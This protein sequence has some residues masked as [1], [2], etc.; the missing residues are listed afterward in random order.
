MTILMK[1]AFW[2]GPGRGQKRVQNGAKTLFFLGNSM[3][4]KLGK[5]ENVIVRNFAVIS[6]APKITL[7]LQCFLTSEHL[8]EGECP[9]PR[10]LAPFFK[11]EKSTKKHKETH[12][13]S[14][15]S[16][17]T[18]KFFMWGPLLLEN[19]GQGATHLK[20]LGVHWG[21]LHSLCGYFFVCVF[22]FSVAVFGS[23]Q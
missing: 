9:D 1:F 23:K 19:K 4:I 14:P 16:D 21:R 13:P 7:F 12:P 17:P 2:R 6:E 11:S 20:N 18:L 10:I 22:F 3:T 15:I 8:C 5:L